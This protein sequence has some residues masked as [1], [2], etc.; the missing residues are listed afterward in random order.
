MEGTKN[1]HLGKL[2]CLG[3]FGFHFWFWPRSEFSPLTALPKI[4][5]LEETNCFQMVVLNESVYEPLIGAKSQ[6]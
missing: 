4:C 3:G 6:T 5:F 2:F 1:K